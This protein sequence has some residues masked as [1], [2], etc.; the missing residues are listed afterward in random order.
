LSEAILRA[1]HPVERR[2]YLL[3]HAETDMV[4]GEGRMWSD[5]EK[6]LTERGRRQAEALRG[7]FSDVDLTCVHASPLART[8]ETAEILA[9]GREV[10]PR[11]AL[12]EISLGECEGRLARDVFAIAPGFLGDPDARLPGGES[13][14]EVADRAEAEVAAILRDDGTVEVAVVAH[15]AVNRGVLGRLLG[16]DDLEALRLRQDWACANVLEHAAGRWWAGALNY[17]PAG[18]DELDQTRRV[19]GLDPGLWRRLGR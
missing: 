12:R 6:P 16:L 15:G 11:A 5:A 7:L 13:F 2:L 4:D 9:G 1:G 3:R 17:T 8:R 10:R 18:L 19:V 14:R